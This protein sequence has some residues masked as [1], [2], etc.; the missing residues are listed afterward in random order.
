MTEK[1]NIIVVEDDKDFRESMG[2]YLQMAGFNVTCAASAL[3]F[4]QKISTQQF[5]LAILDIG[6]PDQTGII[7][8]QYIRT[9]TDM[10]IVMLTAISSL[11]SK[12]KA[13]EAGADIY[14]VKPI[15]FAE[16]VA[17]IYSI[18]GRLEKNNSIIKQQ[19]HNEPTLNQELTQWRLLRNDYTLFTPQGNKTTLTLKEFDLFEKLAWS[20]NT[21]VKRCDLL[22][23]LN[24]EDDELGNRALDALIHRLRRKNEVLLCR[25]PIKTFHG[26][27]YSFTEMILIE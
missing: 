3:E 24:Y 27:G 12:V 25:I 11:D 21:L 5:F 6:L 20:P 19:N 26:T 1:I 18:L 7:L 4:Y 15:D 10:R 8:A 17:S 16:L 23:T 22:N 13:Y 9:N 14:L 2:E